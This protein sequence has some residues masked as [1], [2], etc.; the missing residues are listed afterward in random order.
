MFNSYRI[1]RRISNR[2]SSN[3][4]NLVKYNSQNKLSISKYQSGDLILLVS[5]RVIIFS[6]RRVVD[7]ARPPTFQKHSWRLLTSLRSS[8]LPDLLTSLLSTSLGLLS[9][10]IRMM[11]HGSTEPTLNQT[12]KSAI[13]RI[14]TIYLY[15][16][17]IQD[18]TI[19]H[20]ESSYTFN[21]LNRFHK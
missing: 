17:S 10:T 2:L 9:A 1:R 14:I 21:I 12:L 4:W 18:D 6:H 3:I 20:A 13:F 15:L 7:G 11:L 5:N 16:T 19:L 8:E